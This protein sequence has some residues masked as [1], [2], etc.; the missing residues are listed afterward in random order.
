MRRLEYTRRTRTYPL[1]S[2]GASEAMMALV[3]ISRERSRLDQER[4]TLEK[5][6]RRIES[7]LKEITETE[8]R[9][10]PAVQQLAAKPS[11]NEPVYPGGS[12]HRQ[13]PS[14]STVTLQY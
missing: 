6:I 12:R 14:A 9:L 4:A 1:H 3:H 2:K 11:A 7:R 5:R 8:T 10:I 13:P